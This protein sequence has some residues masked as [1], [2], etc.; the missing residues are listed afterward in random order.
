MASARPPI[1]CK[2][3]RVVIPC[4]RQLRAKGK[5][6]STIGCQLSAV[7]RM[8]GPHRPCTYLKHLLASFSL[9]VVRWLTSNASL[10]TPIPEQG[11]EGMTGICNAWTV[12][13]WRGTMNN[14]WGGYLPIACK[15]AAAMLE[16]TCG[17][18][19]CAPWGPSRM[20]TA[21]SCTCDRLHCHRSE[22]SRGD[23]RCC[24]RIV[25][26]GTSR[27]GRPLQVQ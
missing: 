9:E 16:S 26:R 1:A 5:G 4:P 19:Q 22:G 27:P 13:C 18:L 17:L 21:P 8:K 6:T 14:E 11:S 24:C 23:L 25:P 20:R 15:S 10:A 3:M 7:Q 12:E 2:L